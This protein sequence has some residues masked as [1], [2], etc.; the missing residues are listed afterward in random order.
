MW[1]QTGTY[2]LLKSATANTLGRLC[3]LHDLDLNVLHDADRGGKVYASRYKALEKTGVPAFTLN[4]YHTQSSTLV[5]GK[6]EKLF[7]EELLPELIQATSMHGTDGRELNNIIRQQL[8]SLSGVTP[9]ENSIE[10][11]ICSKNCKT[12]AVFC[13]SGNHWIHY[14]CERLAQHEITLIEASQLGYHCK[15]CSNV[16][17]NDQ[18]TLSLNPST[19]VYGDPTLSILEKNRCHSSHTSVCTESQQSACCGNTMP[20][21]SNNCQPASPCI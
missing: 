9:A 10:C 17:S 3:E 14:R 8:N 4:M 13:E 2:E 12:K 19:D 11:L 7:C 21:T 6:K 5:N 15:S 18:S 20:T 16:A 1:I